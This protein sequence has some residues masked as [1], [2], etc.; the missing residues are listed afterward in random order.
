MNRTTNAA[1][2][3][4]TSALQTHTTYTHII[5]FPEVEQ[6]PELLSTNYRALY[7]A[8]HASMPTRAKA[9]ACSIL[10]QSGTVKDLLVGDTKG[11]SF[12]EFSLA[13]KIIA[14]T[15]YIAIALGA[16]FFAI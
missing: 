11:V 3:S 13:Q 12:G 16:I 9:F 10:Q 6:V 7:Q 15:A 5:D 2:I 1:Y 4:G 8:K 14:P